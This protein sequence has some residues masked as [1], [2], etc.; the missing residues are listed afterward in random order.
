[1]VACGSGALPIDSRSLGQSSRADVPIAALVNSSAPDSGLFLGQF[2][3]AVPISSSELV[4]ADHC[5]AGRQASTID[6][7]FGVSD[8][9]QSEHPGI[10]RFQVER[11]DHNT[12]PGGNLATLV[13]QSSEGVQLP[14]FDLEYLLDSE[15]ELMPGDEAVA[16]GWGRMSVAGVAPCKMRAVALTLVAPELCAN[17][18][19]SL[20]VSLDETVC[21]IPA[22]SANSCD[23]DS[24]GPVLIYR[25]GQTLAIAVT[26][27]GENCGPTDLGFNARVTVLP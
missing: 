5:V 19:E 13:V 21:T 3:A 7:V 2:C 20:P 25:D 8:L 10:T 27:S 22:V 4:T 17:L 24:G 14:D 23:G 18:T 16:Y 9:C 15:N 6:V 1:M 12:G 11:I 26:V